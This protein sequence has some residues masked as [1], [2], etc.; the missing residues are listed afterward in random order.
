[1]SIISKNISSSVSLVEK[2]KQGMELFQIDGLP[3]SIE[4]AKLVHKDN[5]MQLDFSSIWN[6]DIH[7]A[8]NQGTLPP[9]GFSHDGQSYY[10][11]EHTANFFGTI[12]VLYPETQEFHISVGGIND[13]RINPS[14]RYFYRI[15]QPLDDTSWTHD[16][17][18]YAYQDGHYLSSGL[19]EVYLKDGIVQT[20]P[21]KRNGEKYL[22]TDIMY[23]VTISEAY[24]IAYTMA[25]SLG[26]IKSVIFLD[27]YYI[28]A[29]DTDTFENIIGINYQSMRP[30]IHGQYHIFTSNV[31]SLLSTI[32]QNKDIHYAK[33]QLTTEDGKENRNLLDWLQ[34]DTF[35]QLTR[36]LYEDARL[37]R[38]ANI[39][40]EASSQP[41]EH[42]AALY[43][44]ALETITS[45]VTEIK[46]HVY[47][48][49]Y[50]LYE[51][52]VKPLLDKQIDDLFREGVF[53]E[54]VKIIFKKRIKNELDK[55]VNQNKITTAFAEVGYTL[56]KI[57][58]KCIEK[59]NPIFHGADI[60]KRGT[61]EE[62][63]D[64]LFHLSLVLHKLC[65]I[66]LLKLAGFKGYVINNAVLYGFS[67]EIDAKELALI[68]I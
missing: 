33:R 60:I 67:K 16:I 28:I 52:K 21:Y 51:K 31:F 37:L 12:Q 22:V 66:L 62:K 27:E 35:S 10:V 23:S 56:S 57:E 49:D 20:Y 32:E 48:M 39:I 59:R 36:L 17:H 13:C 25:V 63:T 3:F 24:D 29:S 38:T 34:M 46:P 68:E 5:R 50:A 54:R 42:Q 53:D 40:I 41:L 7:K 43:C 26:V 19:L 55:S 61:L 14:D 4:Q 58:E 15:V 65:N 6:T 47:P 30:T 2:F 8:S 1:M 11:P 44:V 18:T 64:Y 45:V 9:F